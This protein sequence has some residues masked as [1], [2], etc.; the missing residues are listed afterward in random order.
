VG[1]DADLVLFDP[2]QT[3]ILSASTHPTR[4]DYSMF[5]GREVTGKVEKV[6][7]R[8][9]LLVDGEQWHGTR[10]YGQFLQRAAS[11]RVL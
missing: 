3:Q 4:V 1:S 9:R 10:G 6:F 11:G 8:G 7:L 2:D 5:E